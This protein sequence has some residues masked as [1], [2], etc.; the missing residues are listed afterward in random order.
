MT[1]EKELTFLW[2]ALQ[3]DEFFPSVFAAKFEYS[4]KHHAS[5]A[6]R[7]LL[8]EL[9]RRNKRLDALH[10]KAC[11]QAR[12]AAQG[13][14]DDIEYD[15]YFAAIKLKQKFEKEAL[16]G[17]GNTTDGI[18]QKRCRNQDSPPSTPL[19]KRLCPQQNPTPL[20]LRYNLNPFHSD[21]LVATGEGSECGSDIVE[22]DE[23]R[24][25]MMNSIIKPLQ[26]HV[27]RA[28]GGTTLRGVSLH[29]VLIRVAQKMMNAR[30]EEFG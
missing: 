30:I 12:L 29:K 26:G 25:R 22:P 11:N 17:V 3:D 14:P 28:K 19:A 1:K 6:L 20:P 27:E 15:N 13:F 16:Y 5:N 21:G 4:V 24:L 9:A 7:N 2:Q 8:E 23:F 10:E 18:V